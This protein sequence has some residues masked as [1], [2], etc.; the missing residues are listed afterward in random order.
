ML[1]LLALVLL[2]SCTCGESIIGGTGGGSAVA[3]GSGRAGGSGGGGGSSGG[4][5]CVNLQCRQTSCSD[6]GTTRLTGTVSIP[7]GTLPL[8]NA[9]VYVPNAPVASIPT[10][11]SC[12]LCDTTPSGSPLV[13]AKTDPQGRF[14]LDDVPA[15]SGIKLIVQAGKWR[16][17]VPL[18]DVPACQET[19]LDPASTRLPRSSSEGHIPRIAVATGGADPLECLLR[20]IGVELSEF[21]QPSGSGRVNVYAGLA[22]TARY[23]ASL[24][25]GEAFP[26][27]TSLWNAVSTLRG[28][29]L[30]L[31]SCEGQLPDP[32][33][34]VMA[35]AEMQAYLHLGGR[36]F[37]SHLHQY[38][39]ANGPGLFPQVATFGVHP[40][41]ASPLTSTVDTTFPRGAELAQW[42]VNTGASSTLGSIDI[43]AA[44]YSIESVNPMYATR[45][46]YAN[47]PPA[48][49]YFS[50][51][52][53]VGAMPQQQCGR[54]VLTDI[55]VSSGD[56]SSTG[57]A[58]PEGCTTTTLSAQEKALIY[59]LFDLSNC[60]SV[61]IN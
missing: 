60:V 9:L 61:E 47:N 31:L 10:G 16:R 54:F 8:H 46:I 51:K 14:V 4:T 30:L 1:R 37:G 33:K 56:T 45:W 19:A 12:D 59:M 36:V 2:S 57:T 13:Q 44:Q 55:H 53:P 35:A 29:D 20:K 34:S 26:P 41:P 25:N 49:Q 52:A 17:E 3:G 28:Y 7:A 40:D 18:P 38:W 27:A 39:V 24:N 50:F 6:G 32:N 42:L 48:V 15:G 11:A 21:T 5:A 23:A 22:G 43:N 58:F